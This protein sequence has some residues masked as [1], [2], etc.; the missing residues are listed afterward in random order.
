MLKR[1]DEVT[2]QR[3]PRSVRELRVV[4]VD[5]HARRR[6]GLS[7]QLAAWG[8]GFTEAETTRSALQALA[9]SSGEKPYDVVLLNAQLFDV[10]RGAIVQHLDATCPEHI[11]A[12]VLVGESAGAQATPEGIHA[13]LASPPRQSQLY[14]VLAAISGSRSDERP[15]HGPRVDFLPRE[16]SAGARES[17]GLPVLVVDDQEIN[18]RVAEVMLARLGYRSITAESGYE[19]LRILS[20][21]PCAAVLMDCRMPNMDGF[22]ATAEIRT[23]EIGQ[24]R[25]TP[26]I[27]LTAHAQVGDRERCLDAGMDDYLSKPVELAQLRGV[28]NRWLPQPA[29][30][31]A[32]AA[33]SSATAPLAGA[34]SVLDRAA[35]SRIEALA[36]PGLLEQLVAA[37]RQSA[38]THLAH[39]RQALAAG[40]AKAL[41]D[42]AHALKGSAL[43][44]G[45]A[46]VHGH[47]VALEL[48]GR[49]DRLADLDPLALDLEAAIGEA[50]D[51]LAAEVSRP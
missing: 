27:A 4:V 13:M 45:A 3:V 9:T 15:R 39:I 14:D 22:T 40:D 6:A 19:A 33:E 48:H 18:R 26:I 35:L 17:D 10:E 32:T 2:V 28:L 49:D 30:G 44:L 34:A 51:A 1:P 16:V 23:A 41:V 29:V 21:T 42:S 8:V 46:G 12:L 11:P 7:E 36:E 37:F 20:H 50:L 38:P 31:S 24:R 5:A 25:Q 47:A 43:A